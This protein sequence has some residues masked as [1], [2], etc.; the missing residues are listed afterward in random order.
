MNHQRTPC[1]AT[2]FAPHDPRRSLAM[3]LPLSLAGDVINFR[4]FVFAPVHPWGVFLL[5]STVIRELGLRVEE[6]F[7]HTPGCHARR[8]TPRGWEAVEVQCTVRSSE[9]RVHTADLASGALLICWE[10]DW[11]ECPVRVVELRTEIE[12]LTR[13]RVL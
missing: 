1:H 13:V 8:R 3:D 2:S 6:I 4:G 10:D 11:P 9:M 5:F 7:P 12:R